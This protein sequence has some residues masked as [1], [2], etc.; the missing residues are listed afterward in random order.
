MVLEANQR[1]GFKSQAA[2]LDDDVAD[3]AA[4]PRHRMQ[5]D[6]PQPGQLFALGGHVVLAQQLVAAADRQYHG[7]AVDGAPNRVHLVLGRVFEDQLLIPILAAAPEDQIDP[8]EV[9]G[10][11]SPD[12]VDGDRNAPPFGSL[13]QGQDVAPIT[14]DIHLVGVEMR[15]SKRWLIHIGYGTADGPPA[16]LHPNVQR[17]EQHSAARRAG[18]RGGA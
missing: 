14:V 10:R 7:A 4:G 9:W 2:G 8:G 13:G 12:G 17:G 16:R 11:P 5:V 3:V 1:R 18:P 6:Q 15:D